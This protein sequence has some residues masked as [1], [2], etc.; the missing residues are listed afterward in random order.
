MASNNCDIFYVNENFLVFDSETILKLKERRL[1]L[2]MIGCTPKAVSLPALMNHYV[3]KLCLDKNMASFK[4][5]IYIDDVSTEDYATRMSGKL[6]NLKA[7]IEQQF[8]LG[9]IAELE[10]RNIEVTESR[11]GTVDEQKL[12]LDI[13]MTPDPDLSNFE[14]IPMT[15]QEI[16]DTL[17]LD[18]QMLAVFNDLYDR[19][20]YVGPGLK[21]GGDFLIY[22]GE[23]SKFHAQYAI[24]VVDNCHGLVDLSRI[25]Y[26]EVNCLARLCYTANKMPLLAT[27]NQDCDLTTY[28]RYWTIKSKNYL[29]EDSAGDDFEP[30]DIKIDDHAQDVAR[31]IRR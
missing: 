5:L 7:K 12:M 21:F 14:V 28:V 18:I 4:R 3:A 27:V 11:I 26:R 30:L 6:R 9:R 13:R 19:G 1:V 15:Q 22:P 24:R 20:F 29:N 25:T 8:R 2:Q 23:P 16:Q 17:R 10:K 31:K